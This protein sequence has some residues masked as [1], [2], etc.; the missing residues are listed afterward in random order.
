M[1]AKIWRPKMIS[2]YTTA[3]YD[4][5]ALDDLLDYSQYGKCMYKSD[6][7][8]D[9]GSERVDHIHFNESEHQQELHKDLKFGSSV[10]SATQL[11]VTGIIKKYWDYFVKEG[12]KRTILGCELGIVTTGAKPIYCRKP[13]YGPYESKVIMTQIEDLLHNRWIEEC[14]GPWGSMMVLAQKPH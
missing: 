7:T 3:D 11:A 10:D 8:W 14:G 13:S 2:R 9:S 4:N 1:P 12:A 5:G 6:V